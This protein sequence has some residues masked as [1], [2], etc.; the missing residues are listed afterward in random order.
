MVL[1]SLYAGVAFSEKME[2]KNTEEKKNQ[3]EVS[4]QLLAI[5][6]SQ[7][8]MK[9]RETQILMQ[10]RMGI[11]I[12]YTL[13]R[14]ALE[15]WISPQAGKSMSYKDS[16]WSNRD[17]HTK[18]FDRILLPGCDLTKF[19]KCQWDPFHS[20]L[21]FTDQ[22]LHIAQIYDQPAVLLWFEKD[23]LVDFKIYG[24]EVQRDPKTFIIDHSDR[25]REFQSA[26]VLSEGKGYFQQQMQ[27]D[28]GRSIYTRAH[29]TSNQVLLI[30]SELQK[31]KIGRK[32]RRWIQ[33]PVDQ[34]LARNE[35]LIAQ[36][37]AHGKFQLKDRP[38]MQKLLEKGRRT[39]LS[40]WNYKGLMRSTNQ[41]IYYLQWIRDAGMNVSHICKTGWPQPAHDST[42]FVLENP[43]FTNENPGDIFFGQMCGG[44]L[45]KWQEDGLFYV[46]WPAFLYWT[47]TGDK[48]ICQ[49]KYLDSM[50]RGVQWLEN[51]AFDR[52]KGLFGRYFA[53]ETAMTGSRDDGWDNV[54]GAPTYKWGSQYKGQTIVRSYDLY[55]NLIHY[56]TYLMLSAM[57]TDEKKALAYYQKATALEKNM[58][59]FF[60]IHGPLPSYGDLLTE[61][62]TW[63]KADPF[64][65]DDW[66]Y[67]WGL[68]L[69][70]FE[71]ND[72]VRYREIRE[73][74]MKDMT[75]TGREYFLCTY[76]GILAG[77]DTEI[78]DE[79]AMMAAMDQQ[80]PWAV[81]TGKYLPM[82]YAMPEMF[83]IS[84]EDVYHDIRPL[85]YSIAPWVS[86]VTN[87]GMHRMPFGIAARGTKYLEK[88]ENY[89]YKGAL[90]D[91]SFSGSGEVCK[92]LLNG[93][94][95][96]ETAQIPEDRLKKGVNKLV[97]E[98]AD[99]E[100]MKNAMVASTVQLD[101]AKEH[102]YSIT[103]YGKNV[104][105]FKNM[106]KEVKILGPN[107]ETVSVE[108]KKM[109]NL[110][111]LEFQ[112][113]G[114]FE[115][116]KNHDADGRK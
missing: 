77:M 44:P 89:A 53:C 91:V 17:D 102:S 112:G 83:N 92:V 79:D 104:L 16:N 81:R 9:Y 22:T 31:E 82:P 100:G 14:N 37:M 80:V 59:S 109:D 56:S 97:I 74:L 58:K 57:H 19:K 40:L 103:A 72:P 1:S 86:A 45:T 36:D 4:S 33:T 88:I 11:R 42:R 8:G 101:S 6:A 3:D 27:L 61:S 54:T 65:M 64:G 47:Q 35:E 87:L 25:Q 46:V 111:F 78:H 67:G 106:D 10:N 84:E 85:V 15:L 5:N 71:I 20:V 113:R 48:S 63:I 99:G 18:V 114:K 32:A 50:D 13:D 66:D 34:I 107:G 24:H 76:F 75:T 51:R 26:A 115:V 49:G 68:S 2:Q 110:T 60:D 55:I 70:P 73:A 95:L 62:G 98:M 90:L 7:Y 30:A 94:E 12:E 43:N 38:Q 41:Y 93:Q 29:M 28:K 39:A 96:S 105:A 69:P 108:T 21:Y 116:V 23:G 52:E